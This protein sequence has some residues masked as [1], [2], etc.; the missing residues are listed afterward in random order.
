MT[1]RETVATAMQEL[2]D[3]LVH[4]RDLLQGQL[5]RQQ[6]ALEELGRAQERLQGEYAKCCDE[7]RTSDSPSTSGNGNLLSSCISLHVWVCMCVC[8]YL[9][10]L[11]H[12]TRGRLLHL[13]K[14]FGFKRTFFSCKGGIKHM[15]CTPFA[16]EG[17][18]SFCYK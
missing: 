14:R 18:K 11:E 1:E 3:D 6:A 2:Q 9:M 12:K 4:Q 13:A 8:R 7:V 10:V 16:T 17:A 5:A 15:F